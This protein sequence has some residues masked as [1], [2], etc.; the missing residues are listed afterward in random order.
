MERDNIVYSKIPPKEAKLLNVQPQS[1]KQAKAFVDAFLK[2]SLPRLRDEDIQNRL[3]RQAVVLEHYLKKRTNSKRKNRYLKSQ[4]R[5]KGQEVSLQHTFTKHKKKRKNK[6]LS[7]KERREMKI[8]D[9]KPDQHRQPYLIQT[10]LLKADL[11]GAI[12]T[13]VK[14]KCPSYVGTTGIILQE[15]KHVFKI[16]TMENKLKVI[17]K[18]NSVFSVEIDRFVSYIYGSKFQLRAGERSARKF[19]VKGSIDL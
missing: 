3:K 16:I 11:H 19:K 14:S 6:C 4:N 10:K 12:V 5:L 13:V 1:S 8:F 2:R 17:P 18:M 7:A 9:L 15:L